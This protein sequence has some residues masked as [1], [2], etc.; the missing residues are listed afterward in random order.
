MDKMGKKR[1]KQILAWCCIVALVVILAVMPLIAAEK[2]QS[3]GPVAVVK[4]AQATTGTVSRTLRSGGTLAFEDTQDITI[5]T[6]VKLTGFLVKN[7]DSV[8]QGDALASVD[9]VSVMTAITQIQD[10]LEYLDQK[11]NSDSG[12]SGT[13]RI[14][15]QTAGVV[16]QV[17]A[18]EG[19]SVQDVMLEYGAL[20]VL[21]LDGNMAVDLETEEELRLG[22]CL[23]V[24]LATGETVEGRVESR[25]GNTFIITVEDEGYPVDLEAEI[26]TEDGTRLGSG[27]LYIHNPW[28]ATAAYG[29]VSKV[30]VKENDSVKKNRTLLTLSDTETAAQQQILVGQRQDY[31]ETMAELFQIYRSGTL[32]APCDGVVDGVDEDSAYLLSGE[33]G[34]WTVMLL[35]NVSDPAASGDGDNGTGDTD[36]ENPDPGSSEPTPT[37]PPT[38]TTTY[39][40]VVALVSS[41]E[42]GS[43]VLLSNGVSVTISDPSLLSPDAASLTAPYSYNGDFHLYTIGEG[44]SLVDSGAVATAGTLVFVTDGKLIALGSASGGTQGGQMGDFSGMMPEGMMGSISG[45]SGFSGYTGGVTTPA[46]EPYDL[47]EATVLTVTPEDTMTLEVPIDELDI[48]KVAVGMTAKITVTAMGSEEY[49][50]TVTQI[51][52]AE[53]SGGNSKF[54]VTLTMDRQGRMLPGMSA[55]AKLPL[56]E[57]QTGLTI[58]TAALWEEGGKTFVYTTYDQKEGTLGTPVEVTVGVV[59]GETVTI[60]AGLTEGQTVYYNYYE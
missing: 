23:N 28:K 3:N 18:R 54:S 37:P 60:L 2:A 38:S 59:D 49:P 7:G 11:I 36:P 24:T 19:D 8:K 30:N 12:S 10:T 32:T 17:Y 29:T 31:E 6:G 34:Q 44:G 51:G 56:G 42:N 33:E 9:K 22:D 48:S 58:P 46:F 13:T 26:I 27:K 47:T 21:S 35:S 43:L 52:T 57:D 5:P 14:Q 40:G 25:L 50:A 15:A 16:K 20:A 39:T 53:N 1:I 41:D 45:F 55:S 4:S